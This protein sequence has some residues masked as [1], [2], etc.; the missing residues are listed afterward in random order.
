MDLNKS[1]TGVA[2]GDGYVDTNVSSVVAKEPD[3]LVWW[4]GRALGGSGRAGGVKHPQ[5]ADSSEC[6]LPFGRPAG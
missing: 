1:T 2:E 6:E 5:G 3:I 4:E